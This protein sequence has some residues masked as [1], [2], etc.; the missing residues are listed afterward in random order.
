MKSTASDAVIAAVIARLTAAID[1]AKVEPWPDEPE[2]Y[3]PQAR[4]PILLVT[5]TEWLFTKPEGSSSDRVTRTYQLGVLVLTNSL[6]P[7]QGGPSLIDAVAIALGGWRP[8]GSGPIQLEAA[9][10]IDRKDGLHRYVVRGTTSHPFPVGS[11]E[12]LSNPLITV[13]VEGDAE[14]V[15]PPPEPLPSH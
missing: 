7:G 1:G 9:Q 11:D 12:D 15:I 13:I 14:Q 4:V 5:L 2:K 3:R 8:S 6:K 10:M